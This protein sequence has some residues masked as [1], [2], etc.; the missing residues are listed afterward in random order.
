[1]G[2]HH[3]VLMAIGLTAAAL[4]GCGSSLWLITPRPDV[5]HYEVTRMAPV[6][7]TST[8][9]RATLFVDG[10]E[11]GETPKTIAVP[12]REIRRQRRQATWPAIVGTGLDLV[13]GVFGVA[14]ALANEVPEAAVIIGAGTVG[15]ILLDL[16]LITGRSTVNEGLDTLAMPV[17]IGVRAEGFGDAARRVR[18][19]ELTKLHFQL[20]PGAAPLDARPPVAPASPVVPPAPSAPPVVPR[21]AR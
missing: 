4:P 11:A 21:P 20:A 17:E 18:V 14:V 12:Y 6:D 13:G 15:V 9:P 16:Y 10:A 8:P 19:P 1:M 7:V 3:R 2:L 5:T